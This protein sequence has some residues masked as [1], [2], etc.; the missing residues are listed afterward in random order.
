MSEETRERVLRAAGP[1]F[2]QKGF[3][4]ATVREICAAA[5]VN[6]ASVNYHFGSKERLYVET[7]GLAHREKLR[8]VPL[9]ELQE[10]AA[11]E[12]K[13]QMFVQTMLRRLLYD[14]RDGWET[15]LL[16]REM[17]QPT[18]ACRPLVE[19]YIRPQFD[20]LL[21]IIAE[22]LGE[23][24]AE[25]R[26]HQIAFSIVGQCLHYRVAHEFVAILTGGEVASGSYDLEHLVAHITEF[27]LAAIRGQ[28]TGE[29]PD[30]R[31]SP[32]QTNT[33]G[34]ALSAWR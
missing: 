25:T 2:A 24:S 14:G 6:L 10:H 9:P 19:D 7:V 32:T 20:F 11:P 28:A 8:R 18:H 34:A 22:L 16:V 26:R 27:T 29:V 13:L 17:L 12:I 30:S 1:I 4:G 21:R 3:E 33:D 15:Q 31:T 5:E 23:E